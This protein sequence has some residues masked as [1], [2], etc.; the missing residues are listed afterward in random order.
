MV[1][2]DLRPERAL[3][4]LEMGAHSC[5]EATLVQ[6]RRAISRTTSSQVFPDPNR[7]EMGRLT[8]PTR[9]S[10]RCAFVTFATALA[11]ATRR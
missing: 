11:A 6:E 8:H 4:R 5:M 7:N 3:A 2:Q 1:P 10:I 9:S